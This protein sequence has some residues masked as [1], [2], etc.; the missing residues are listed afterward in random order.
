MSK[1]DRMAELRAEIAANEQALVDM[2]ANIE[3]QRAELEK[4]ERNVAANSARTLALIAD[5]QREI[6]QE[7]AE[8]DAKELLALAE[9]MDK[10]G[11]NP[12][13]LG[14]YLHLVASLRTHRI[15]TASHQR[16]TWTVDRLLGNE[17]VPPLPF[18]MR[19]WSAC[20]KIWVRPPQ[21]EKAA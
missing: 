16:V 2:R 9:T 18:S 3:R 12:A 7:Q 17:K 4:R 10:D 11:Q 20:A 8:L 19:S 13:T 6:E 14:R 1:K 5:L 15:V 21:Q